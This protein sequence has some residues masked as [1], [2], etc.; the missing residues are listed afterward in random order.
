MSTEEG[1]DAKAF[2]KNLTTRPGIYKMFNDQAE[3]IY[4]GKAKNLKN[5]VSSYFK[6]NNASTKQQAM[7]AKIANIEVTVTHTESEALLLECQ[8]IKQHKPRYN[9]LLRDDKSFPYVFISTHQ[10]FPQITIHRGAKNKKGRYFGP[11]PS[12]GAVRESLKLLQ[13]LFPVRQ[14]CLQQSLP[15]LFTISD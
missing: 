5:R 4:I 10:D 6:S 8:Q 12:A 2:L 3:I 14:C 15:S 11:Y 7:V 9:I 1:F 13:K